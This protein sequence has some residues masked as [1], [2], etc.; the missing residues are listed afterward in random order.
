MNDTTV[1]RAGFG[2]FYQPY[3]GQF[4]DALLEGNGLSQT[5]ILVNPNQTNAPLFPRV[6]TFTS[7]P[8]GTSNLM[9]AVNKL[10]NPHTQQASLALEKQVAHATTVT[11]S[12]I[13]S[14]AIKLWT[15]A[16]QNLDGAHQD[17]DLPHR[18]CRGRGGR[19]RIPP[20]CGP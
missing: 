15:G 4:I 17:A 12:L 2:F 7:A 9:Y 3:S 5:S 13:N 19:T 11:L 18:Q 8:T 20:T 16:D 1:V 14:R 10:R 6:L